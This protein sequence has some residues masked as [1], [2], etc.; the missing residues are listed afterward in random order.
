MPGIFAHSHGCK[1]RVNTLSYLLR[2]YTEVF[3][4]KRN[5]FF[6][7]GRDKLIIGILKH[8]SDTAAQLYLLLVGKLVRN[9]DAVDN[10]LS[11]GRFKYHI[12]ELGKGRFSRAVPANYRDIFAALYIHGEILQRKVRMARFGI[13]HKRKTARLYYIVFTDSG[14]FHF[15]LFSHYESVRFHLFIRRTSGR[16]HRQEE[17][18]PCSLPEALTL[19]PRIHLRIYR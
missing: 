13:V 4:S 18:R 2:G 1:C 17:A 15:C 9:I 19:M 11:G 3:R 5:I 12:K 8:H 7:N 14:N 16:S 10:E 6:D